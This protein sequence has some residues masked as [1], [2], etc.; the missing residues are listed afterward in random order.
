MFLGLC[1]ID[2]V[3]HRLSG[4]FQVISNQA[5]MATPPQ[6]FSTHHRRAS[7]AGNVGESFDVIEPPVD[8]ATNMAA[9]DDT[10]QSL[11]PPAPQRTR[12]TQKC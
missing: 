1:L 10:S 9:R 5:A 12:V 11:S 2:D 7:S 3:Y 4:G 6:R 8:D